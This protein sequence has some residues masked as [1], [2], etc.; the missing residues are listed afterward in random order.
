MLPKLLRLCFICIIVIILSIV[1]LWNST[2]LSSIQP[3]SRLCRKIFTYL[4][5]SGVNIQSDDGD[6]TGLI[7]Y[8]Q[9]NTA[10]G[11]P[12]IDGVCLSNPRYVWY[13]GQLVEKN[14]YIS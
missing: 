2:M 14:T 12:F 10:Y 9:A 3:E 6:H 5:T 4:F 8:I 1:L 13:R 11:S 7:P